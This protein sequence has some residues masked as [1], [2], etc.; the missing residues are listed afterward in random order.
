M[1]QLL[2]YIFFLIPLVLPAQETEKFML[3]GEGFGNTVLWDFYCSDGYNSKEWKKIEVPSNWE[4]QGFGEYTYGRWY[5][6]PAIKQPSQE[7]GLYKHRFT[8]P[9]S[10]KGKTIKIVFEG[11]MTDTEVKVNNK[12]AG[13]VH[14]GGFYRF[15]YDI[16]DKV[17]LGQENLLEVKVSKHSSDKSVNGAERRADWWLFGG[18]YRPVYL[19]AMPPQHI[20]HVAID[21][22]MDGHLTTNVSLS[23]NINT[24]NSINISLSTLSGKKL[25]NRIFDVKGKDRV[26]S[27]SMVW[28]DVLA[29]T[30]ETPNLYYIQFD[31]LD[32]NKNIIHTRKERI[33]FRTVEFRRHDGLYVNN[34]KIVLKGINRHSF[35]PDGGRTTNREISLQDAKLIKEMNINAVRF[36]Y[37][38]DTHFLDMCDS[39]GLF[40]I[41]ELAGWQNSYRAEVG[42]NLLKEMVER[43]VNHPSII[44]WSNGNEGGWNK[45][46]DS[47]F[48]DYDPQ[49]RHVIHPW[50]DFDGLDTHHYP[51]Y[52]TGIARF[53]NGSNVFMPTEFMHGMYDQ[54][55]GAGLEDFWSKYT[56]HS[57]FAGGF[58]WDFSDNAVRRTDRGGILDTD[59]N[60]AADG[61]LGPYR[62]KEASYYTVREVWS[63]IRIKPLMI[64]PSFDGIIFVENDYLFSDLKGCILQYNVYKIQSSLNTQ[65]EQK[66]ISSDRLTLPDIQP[67]EV[68]RIRMNLPESFFN[69]DVLE[70]KAF[71]KEGYEVCTRTFPIKTAKVYFSEQAVANGSIAS[72][73]RID[74]DITVLSNNNVDITFDN[75]TGLLKEVLKDGKVIP[76]NNGPIPIGMKYQFKEA[77]T[78]TEDGVAIFTA[79]YTGMLDSI[80]WRLD[81]NGL[82]SMSALM[83]NKTARSG[84]FDDADGEDKIT[85][86][87][88]SF[89]YPEQA[90]EAV[91][92]FGRGPYRVWKNRIPGMNFGLWNKEYNNTITGESDGLLVYPEFKG[93]HANMYWCRFFSQSP[94]TV[95]SESDNVYLRLFTPEEPKGRAN[96]ENIMPDFPEGDISFLYE[97][98]AIRDFKPVSQ[99]GPN[100]Q[101]SSIRIKRGD[102]GIRMILH[103]DFK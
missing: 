8:I 2:L 96:G 55:H 89:S 22:R 4:L 50:A 60:H 23:G 90:V 31:L 78:R 63:P 99:H 11:V 54:G 84:G 88:F 97:I 80:Q 7:T 13:A 74:G 5:K 42:K 67:K 73:S 58:L 40:V 17:K 68:R 37:P 92:W 70:I 45:E 81:K 103:F 51:E 38:P 61:I 53:T 102:E 62:E 66:L 44:I 12:L 26:Q 14:Q 1:K 19:E 48:R 71:D 75:K 34:V 87:G 93:Y 95:Y 10:W 33:G 46:L 77:K 25:G 27:L 16:S 15:S 56:A 76:F 98:P 39:L 100:S 18:I 29:W 72:S 21:A 79:Y 82:L 43:D 6:N 65:P 24:S 94:F 30:S 101:P 57:L 59:N 3:S 36:H 85:N 35:W 41:D 28:N 69:G 47:L 91:E 83:L 9:A 49:Q 64:T 32:K 52:Q 86:F 20:D